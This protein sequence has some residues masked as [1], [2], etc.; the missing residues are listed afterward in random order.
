MITGH[1]WLPLHI[2][3]SHIYLSYSVN[4]IKFSAVF[5]LSNI[6]VHTC[7]IHVARFRRRLRVDVNVA[8]LSPPLCG[9][10]NHSSELSLLSLGNRHAWVTSDAS[11]ITC[12]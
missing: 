6:H 8:Q 5:M 4:Q 7:S 1:R 2:L 3:S 10:G 9:R 12:L 11:S